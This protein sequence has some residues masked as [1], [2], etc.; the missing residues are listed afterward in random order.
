M[1]QGKRQG[2]SMKCVTEKGKEKA[3]RSRKSIHIYIYI[4]YEK[5]SPSEKSVQICG[6]ISALGDGETR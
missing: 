1:H 6:V 4:Y 2:K 3:R 5:A